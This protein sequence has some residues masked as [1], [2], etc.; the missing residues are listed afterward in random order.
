MVE[1]EQFKFCLDWIPG[2][3]NL[4]ADSLS[5][6]LDVDPDA[7][8][9]GEAE[10]HEF[11]S[12]C[13]EELEPEKVLE[14]VFTEVIEPQERNSETVECSLISQM[15]PHTEDVISDCGEKLRKL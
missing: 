9:T 1:L 8:Q 11:G 12:Y 4:L 15:T 7:Q 2:S 3:Q 5:H 6:L 10:G 14:T 13:F